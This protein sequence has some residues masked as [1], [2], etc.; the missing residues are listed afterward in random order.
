MK[1]IQLVLLFLSALLMACESEVK[2]T[3]ENKIEKPYVTEFGKKVTFNDTSNTLYFKL[4]TARVQLLSEDLTA[5][6]RVVSSVVRNIA[7]KTYNLVIFSDPEL[8]ANFSIYLERLINI[9]T[10]NLNYQRANDLYINGAATGREL[11]EAQTMLNN[12]EAAIIENE[13]KFIQAGLDPEDFQSHKVGT[14]WII[15][16][17]PED[18]IN[19]IKSGGKCKIRFNS[20][21]NEYFNGV[22]ENVGDVVDNTTRMVKLRIEIH[23][24]TGKIKVGMFATVEFGVTEG[25]FLCVPDNAVVTVQ[26]KDYVF[27][28]KSANLFERVEVSAGQQIR[29]KVIIFSGLKPNDVVVTDGVMQLKGLSF[30]Y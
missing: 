22:V 15:S 14:A 12:E 13:A 20:Y 30:G 21:E 1:K 26:G 27:V 17:I 29:N 9:K 7:H 11:I 28:K 8:T 19:K 10:Y 18:D 2:D 16:D 3:H 5:P 24:N 23:N 6:A 25:S 4:D